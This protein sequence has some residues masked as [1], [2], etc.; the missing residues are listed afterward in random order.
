MAVE[1]QLW[2]DGH[3][4]S[5]ADLRRMAMVNY[6]ALTSFSYQAGGVRGLDLHLKRL[7]ASGQELFGQQIS[8]SNILNSLRIALE[9]VDEAWV[10]VTLT[11]PDLSIR[12]P[13]QAGDVVVGLWVSAPA[14]ALAD[15]QRI[16]AVPHQRELAHLK[17]LGT[18]GI[19]HAR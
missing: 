14:Q 17:H 4:A 7:I 3:I 15:G 13:E 6:G 10:R 18:T 12:T 9:A 11:A 1:P 5:A 2:I 19:I 16:S 8:K